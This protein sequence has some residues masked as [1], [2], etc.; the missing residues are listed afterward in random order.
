MHVWSNKDLRGRCLFHLIKFHPSTVRFMQF[1]N[2]V[3]GHM[4]TS[5]SWQ[6]TVDKHYTVMDFEDGEDLLQ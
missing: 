2:P 1:Y 5:L 6:K 4:V 3:F